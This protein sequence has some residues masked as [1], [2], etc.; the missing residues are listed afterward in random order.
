V[1]LEAASGGS[2]GEGACIYLAATSELSRLAEVIRY[3]GG[4]RIVNTAK[5]KYS[6]QIIRK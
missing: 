2:G 3:R 1:V 6:H 4:S 5:S